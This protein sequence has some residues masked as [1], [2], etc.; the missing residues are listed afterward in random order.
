LGEVGVGNTTVAAALAAGLL[1]LDAGAVV[2]LGAGA[3]SAILQ[4]KSEVVAA[5]L[6]RWRRSEPGPDRASPARWIAGLGG[7]ELGLLAGVVR[8]VARAGGVVVLDGLATGVAALVAVEA[9]PGVAAHLVAGQRSRER[10]H[11]LVLQRLGL[12]PLLDLRLRAGEGVGAAL[13]AQLLISG[14]TVRD[15]GA[16]TTT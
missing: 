15:Q 10:A 14:L 16:R 7:P 8:G 13:A 4:R 11:A 6:L 2:G 3:D 9:E 1:G 5:A 12:E